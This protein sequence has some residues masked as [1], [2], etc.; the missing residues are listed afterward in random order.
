MCEPATVASVPAEFTDSARHTEVERLN[1]QHVR[2]NAD[3]DR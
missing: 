2:D 1:R 3:S